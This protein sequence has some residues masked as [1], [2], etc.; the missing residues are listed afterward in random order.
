M[1]A[2]V[3]PRSCS[4]FTPFAALAVLLGATAIAA[5]SGLRA[6]DGGPGAPAA[7]PP[8][9]SQAAPQMFGVQVLGQIQAPRR[10][11]F[12]IPTDAPLKDL[13]PAAPATTAVR[14]MAASLAA[15]PEVAFQ[16]PPAKGI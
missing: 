1:S 2:R 4:R 8:P 13:L 16:A 7:V 5:V 3:R 6:Q 14:A 9:P 10:F 12:T 11:Q 15:V